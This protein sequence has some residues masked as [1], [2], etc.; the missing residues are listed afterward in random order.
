MAVAVL[1]HGR[2]PQVRRLA[3]EIIVTQQ[4]E[5]VAMRLA[6]GQ[7]LPPSQPS[8]VQVPSVRQ[9]DSKSSRPTDLVKEP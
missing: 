5:I 1:R 2:N 6:V 3:Q 7:P 9:I 8:P 4:Q